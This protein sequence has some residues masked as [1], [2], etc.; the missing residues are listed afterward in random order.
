MKNLGNIERV[1]KYIDNHLDEQMGYERIANMFHFSP[2]HFHRIFSIIAGKTITAH[3]RDRRLEKACVMLSSSDK[4][5]LELCLECGFDAYSSFSRIFKRKYGLS[6]KE[7]RKQGY[8]PAVISV[9]ELITRFK[10]NLEGGK[11]SENIMR[12]IEE[13]SKKIEIEP[14]SAGN[15]SA[16]GDSYQHLGEYTKAISDYTR[17]IELAPD[18]A[19]NFYGRG[20]AYQNLYQDDETFQKSV[21]DFT[22]AIELE[23]ENAAFFL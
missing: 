20:L 17:A 14:N 5:I 4:S 3:I 22:R 6:P 16:R 10:E 15:F 2:Y 1:L 19:W 11:M 7:Y 13:L 12:E 8:S 9:E 23:P 21:D 18:S